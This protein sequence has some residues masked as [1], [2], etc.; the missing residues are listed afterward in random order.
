[1]IEK[2]G[3]LHTP[4]SKKLTSKASPTLKSK[5]E[6]K[7]GVF[8]NMQYSS[9]CNTLAATRE[10]RRI[11]IAKNLPNWD[12]RIEEEERKKKVFLNWPAMA[13]KPTCKKN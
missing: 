10:I 5:K 6:M 3:A 12:Q 13:S 4:I 9:T 7:G 2:E 8:I 1:M 11:G